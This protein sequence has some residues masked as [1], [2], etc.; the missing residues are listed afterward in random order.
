M[1]TPARPLRL[2]PPEPLARR[3]DLLESRKRR[4][5]ILSFLGPERV[6][7]EWWL[8][9]FA[10]DYY[11]VETETE[12]LWVFRSGGGLFLHGIFD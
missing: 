9:G 1:A 10:R 4:W 11:Q 6:S 3:G 8:G 7:G 2:F 12:R 5:R